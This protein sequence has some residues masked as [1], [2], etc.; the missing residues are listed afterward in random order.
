MA[1]SELIECPHIDDVGL[2]VLSELEE[3]LLAELVVRLCQNFFNRSDLRLR[4][5]LHQGIC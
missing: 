2:W 3:A 4:R 1:C 5:N